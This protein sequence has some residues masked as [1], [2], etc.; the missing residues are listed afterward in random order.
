[1]NSSEEKFKRH[2]GDI[3]EIKIKDDT[4]QMKALG[5]KHLARFMNVV[6][7]LSGIKPGT[8]PTPEIMAS[9]FTDETITN[10]IELMIICFKKANPE[11]SDATLEEFVGENFWDIFPE[12]AEIN[13]MK[14]DKNKNLKGKLEQMREKANASP[15][16]PTA[17]ETQ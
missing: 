16:V 6:S 12:F 15:T 1:M 7:K 5:G 4:F 8:V 14:D 17:S 11:V 13:G 2:L 3:Y 10:L 9:V